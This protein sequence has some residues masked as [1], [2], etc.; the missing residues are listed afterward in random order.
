[1]VNGL[2]LPFKTIV[3]GS[4]RQFTWSILTKTLIWSVGL[5]EIFIGVIE[6]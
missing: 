3:E 4:I 5:N 6:C 1:V 2:I